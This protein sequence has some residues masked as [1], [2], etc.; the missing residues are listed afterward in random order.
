[1]NACK[2]LLLS[3]AGLLFHIL[4]HRHRGVQNIS[5]RIRAPHLLALAAGQLSQYS[6]SLRVGTSGDRILV[7]GRNFPCRP[8]WTRGPPSLLYKTCRVSSRV[9]RPKLCAEHPP[10]SNAG[11]RMGWNYTPPSVHAQACHRVTSNFVLYFPD[12]KYPVSLFNFIFNDQ[13]LSKLRLK[14]SSYCTDSIVDYSVGVRRPEGRWCLPLNSIWWPCYD[15]H[16]SKHLLDVYKE[17]TVCPLHRP[18]N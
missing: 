3:G 2:Q 16:S 1:M 11:L 4:E 9:K 12:F 10:P 15:L 6:K 18:V 8:E 13:H 17:Q 14:I 5:V 7:G